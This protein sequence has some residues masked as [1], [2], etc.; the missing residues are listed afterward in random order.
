MVEGIV[1]GILGGDDEKPEVEATETLTGA[2]SFAAAIVAMLSGND[3][4]VA[5][6]TSTFLGKQSRLLEIQA[7]QIGRAHV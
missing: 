2:D 3:P 7:R 6:D 5:R 1:G 4:Q